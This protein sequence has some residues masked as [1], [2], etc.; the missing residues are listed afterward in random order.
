[1]SRV[2]RAVAAW[3]REAV[4]VV[5]VASPADNPG[6]N[7]AA[8]ADSNRELLVSSRARWVRANLARP[9]GSPSNPA[10][11][12]IGSGRDS[13]EKDS[14]PK[15]TDARPPEQRPGVFLRHHGIVDSWWEGE[16][17]FCAW[18][19]RQHLARYGSGFCP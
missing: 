14:I 4:P 18:R 3:A 6:S 5:K 2:D 17:G 10:N 12:G 15:H 16:R 13:P 7:R 9:R 19:N 11:R 8:S 1:A